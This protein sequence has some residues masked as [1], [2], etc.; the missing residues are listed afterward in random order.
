MLTVYQARKGGSPKISYH[1]S[2][3]Q[4]TK[5]EGKLLV[6]EMQLTPTAEIV[7][8]ESPWAASFVNFA[9]LLP[10][11]SSGSSPRAV[12]EINLPRSQEAS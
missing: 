7:T 8:E 1:Q 9:A 12:Y 11:K 2:G 3:I 4:H 6:R 10:F 5:R